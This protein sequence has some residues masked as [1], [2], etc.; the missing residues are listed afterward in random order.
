MST[1]SKSGLINET[2]NFQLYAENAISFYMSAKR[3]ERAEEEKLPW[4]Q[5]GTLKSRVSSNSSNISSKS[6]LDIFGNVLKTS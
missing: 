6:S 5:N 1:C 3:T 2:T 4:N